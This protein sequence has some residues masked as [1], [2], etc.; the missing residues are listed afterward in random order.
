MTTEASHSEPAAHGAKEKSA[1]SKIWGFVGTLVVVV[2]GLIV[3]VAVSMAL[4]PQTINDANSTFV[5]IANSM[6]AFVNNLAVGIPGILKAIG[7]FVSKTITSVIMLLFMP[8][9]VMAI[10]WNIAQYLPDEWWKFW[11]KKPAE[12]G[13]AAH[14]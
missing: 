12:G 8:L 14:H 11:K 3:V 5:A 10:L 4:I 1:G 9:L 7:L 6:I 13:A 2:V